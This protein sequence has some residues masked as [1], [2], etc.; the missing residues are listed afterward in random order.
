MDASVEIHAPI[1]SKVVGYDPPLHRFDA[2][3]GAPIKRTLIRRSSA[4]K[5]GWFRNDK[6]QINNELVS[7]VQALFDW[8]HED[9]Q[10]QSLGIITMQIVETALKAALNPDD[11]DIDKEWK[12]FGQSKETLA[13]A[14]KRLG[15]IVQSWKGSIAFG[16]YGAVRGLNYMSNVDCLATLG[17]PWPNLG[18][19]Q[20]E[21]AFLGLKSGW[22]ARVDALCRAELEQAHG[23]IR[24]VH[25]K[26][27]GRALHIGKILPSGSGWT[28]G[29]LEIRQRQ[30]GRA[31]LAYVMPKDELLTIIKA[32]GGQR[33][34]ARKLGCDHT[35][36]ARY[37]KG[38]A[39]KQET[40]KLLRELFDQKR[41]TSLS[42]T[43]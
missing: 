32:F 24:P 26:K 20:N 19:V 43:K 11:K 1:L 40:A 38:H 35:T 7:G 37:L 3:D 16:H 23:R 22:Q 6:L 33:A 28:S 39:M 2:P 36:I 18:E 41:S 34:T 25:R 29:K 8:A 13:L 5:K 9:P 14:R 17:E 42:T 31:P 30:K 12:A 10:S 21:V 15:P 27:P 4:T